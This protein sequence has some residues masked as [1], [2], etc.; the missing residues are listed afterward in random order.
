VDRH[1]HDHP[2]AEARGLEVAADGYRDAHELA[3]ADH[4]R[5]SF[6]GRGVTTWQ[7][8]VFGFTGGL[9][10]CPAAVTVL[11]LCLQ[12][13]ELALGFA[14]VLCFSIGLAM[15]LVFVGVAAAL[16][17][18]HATRRWSWLSPLARREPYLSGAL[19]LIVGVSIG[20]QGLA[21]LH[22]A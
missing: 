12:L 4:I 9:I 22:H 20:L 3:H 16:G 2:H 7:I 1:G 18:R 14:L 8:I 10:P 21:G 19:I 6:S 17:M 15:T 13:R 5:R 11:L